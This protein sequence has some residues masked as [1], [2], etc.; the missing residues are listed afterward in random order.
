MAFWE[1]P[2]VNEKT[3]GEG[4]KSKILFLF[5]LHFLAC[6][7]V[8]LHTGLYHTARPILFC[9]C[10]FF[11]LIGNEHHLSCREPVLFRFG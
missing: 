5:L 1:P 4:S 3:P 7:A 10:H 8:S 2:W 11:T 9:L 6:H